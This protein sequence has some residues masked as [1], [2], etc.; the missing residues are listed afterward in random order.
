MTWSTRPQPITPGSILRGLVDLPWDAP[1]VGPLRLM[2]P[3]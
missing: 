1:L 3:R 2:R